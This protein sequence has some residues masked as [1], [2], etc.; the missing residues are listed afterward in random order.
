MAPLVVAQPGNK[1][2]RA[3][4]GKKLITTFTA[5]QARKLLHSHH[6]GDLL[7]DM[8]C[9]SIECRNWD[10]TDPQA[11]CFATRC[12]ENGSGRLHLLHVGCAAHA[13]GQF[14]VVGFHKAEFFDN[15]VEALCNWQ[16][17][18]RQRRARGRPPRSRHTPFSTQQRKGV[19][20][21]GD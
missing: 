21:H 18:K 20:V 10:I 7:K 16:T 13:H 6:E 17:P 1:L 3:R 9:R 11:C 15:L 2:S 14:K 4:S 19:L 12:D 5:E 8:Q